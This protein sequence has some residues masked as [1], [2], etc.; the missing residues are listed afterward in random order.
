MEV[1]QHTHTGDP[2]LHRG[3]KKWHHYFWEF[4]MLFLAVTL[5]FLVEN[6]REHFVEHG[7]AR[8]Y[9]LSLVD[10][11]KNDTIAFNKLKEKYWSDIVKIDTLRKILK[12]RPVAKIPGGTLYYYCEP[13]LWSIGITFHDATI[14]QLKNSGNLRYFPAQL[15]YKISEYDRKT[16][17]LTFRQENEVYFSRVTR[18]MM[19]GIFDA[20]LMISVRGLTT[21]EAIESFKQ[22]DVNMVKKDSLTLRKLVN[23]IIYRHASWRYRLEGII[24]PTNNAAIELLADVK[25]A[26]H[27]E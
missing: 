21:P 3:K 6:Q 23:E 18:E 22:A 26:Y 10:D 1:H 4:F 15:Q 7:R 8:Q 16:R 12:E 19:T 17:E 5:G 27:I 20:E 11:L 2:D 25:K 24:E 13:T 14:Q 9:A